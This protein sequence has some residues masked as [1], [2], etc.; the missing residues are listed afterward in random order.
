[1]AR[2]PVTPEWLD[3]GWRLLQRCA[4]PALI[5]IW[6]TLLVIGLGLLA[7]PARPLLPA[8]GLVITA[9]APLL[10]LLGTRVT[11]SDQRRHPVIISASMGLGCSISM[12]GIQRFGD[13]HQWVLILCLLALSLWMLYQ[14]YIWRKPSSHAA[15]ERH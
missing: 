2:R 4:T 1:M 7:G 3:G 8:A 5:L 9:A 10:F 11:R 14:R 12:V 15:D 6:L 13:S